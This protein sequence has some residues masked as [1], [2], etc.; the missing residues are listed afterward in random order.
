MRNQLSERAVIV[1]I[2]GTIALRGDRNPYSVESVEHDKPN[3]PVIE[4]V[5]L[6]SKSGVQMVFVSGRLEAAREGTIRFIERHIPNLDFELHMRP[7]GDFQPDQDLKFEIYTKLIAPTKDVWFV[8]DDRDKV[9]NMWRNVLN[10]PT[11][12]VGEGRF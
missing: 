12:Q 8:L 9:V 1:D 3:I 5:K 11:F 7:N 4:L 2:D 10:L 6:L